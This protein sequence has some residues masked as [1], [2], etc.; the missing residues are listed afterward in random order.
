MRMWLRITLT[1]AVVFLFVVLLII[2]F[3]FLDIFRTRRIV[4]EFTETIYPGRR[5]SARVTIEQLGGAKRASERLSLYFKMPHCIAPHRVAAVVLLYECGNHGKATLYQILEDSDEH[6]AVRQ[7]AARCLRVTPP[8]TPCTPT[9]TSSPPRKR[10]ETP[11]P[12]DASDGGN[13]GDE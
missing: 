7:M 4:A 1:M 9:P 6:Y 3:M 13:D 12:G 11:A 2:F 5:S 8:A 10:P